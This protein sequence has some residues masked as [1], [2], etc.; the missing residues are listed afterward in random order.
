MSSALRSGGRRH[1]DESHDEPDERWAVSYA[2]MVTVLMCL[3]IVLFAVSNVDK[4]KFE[5]LANSLATGFGQEETTTGGADI[6]EGLV[7]PPEMEDENGEA[8]LTTRAEVEFESLE[9]LRERITASL[10]AQGL[11]DT[12]EFV[13]DDRGLKV[14]L[15]GAETF[16]GD[17]STD[18]SAKADSVLDA[19][20]DVLTTVDNQVSIEGHADRR[21]AAE[22]YP[23]NWELS[24]G[25]AT[26]VARFLVEHERIAGA[27][28]KAIAFSDTRPLMQG[29]SP[30][31]L[32]SNRRVDIVVESNEEDQVRALLPALAEA[33]EKS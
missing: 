28:V 15:V 1:E 20:G 17:N 2:D 14:G 23:T 26:Q 18:L 24:G 31:A 22:P 32:A 30:E 9:E 13:I 3:F 27:R 4:T 16:F 11:Q 29:D 33:A 25:R 19:I 5:L 7:I 21:H 10:T 6:S 8:D 12:V